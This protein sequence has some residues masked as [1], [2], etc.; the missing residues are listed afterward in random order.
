MLGKTDT[1]SKFVQELPFHKAEIALAN[2][3]LDFIKEDNLSLTELRNRVLNYGEWQTE[4]DKKDSITSKLFDSNFF[5]SSFE[6]KSENKINIKRFEL[7]SIMSCQ[8]SIEDRVDT[9]MKLINQV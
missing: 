6:E 2:N 3:F 7:F 8:T 9:F 1:L 4:L 5:K